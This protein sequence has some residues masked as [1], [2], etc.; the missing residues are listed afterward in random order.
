MTRLLTAL[1]FTLTALALAAPSA[2]AQTVQWQVDPN[3]SEV[4]FVARHL[5]FAKVRGQFRSFAATIQA[6]AKT[7]KLS[8]VEAT[9][10]A[11]SVDTDNDKRDEHLRSD[12]FFASKKFPKLTL[13]TKSI[14]WQGDSFKAV[15]ALS[16]RG[17]TKDVTFEGEL[18]GVRTVN[19]GQGAHQRAAYE[20]RAKI[21]RQDFGLNFSGVAEGLAIVGDEV[22]IELQIETFHTPK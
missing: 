4:G 13:K 12:D 9:V 21:K 11:G 18:L 6:D 16:I 17:V 3:H 22:Q 10:E 5:A 14:R 19:F 8:A 7:G 20:A 2:L 15:V 1:V